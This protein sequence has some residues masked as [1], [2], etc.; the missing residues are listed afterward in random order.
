MQTP[1][2]APRRG[3]KFAEVKLLIATLSL[4]VVIGIWNLLANQA[5]QAEKAVSTP[6]ETPP[7][8][9][10]TQD[11]SQA[12]LPTLV[13]LV[14]LASLPQVS[15]VG[16]AVSAVKNAPAQQSPT[17]LRSVTIPTQTIVQKNRVNIEQQVQVV[18][19]G[20]GG[21]GGG[22]G[23]GAAPA[24]VTTTRSSHP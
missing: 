19:S 17:T 11:P 20:R 6:V 2:P 24:P 14:D 7:L 12:A 10:S 18:V 16:Q 22:G 3:V 1:K 4:A 21:G 23:G 5:V 15:A 13:P 8:T 9:G